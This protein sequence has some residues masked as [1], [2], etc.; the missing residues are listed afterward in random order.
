ML[1]Q[2]TGLMLLI[3]LWASIQVS[4]TANPHQADIEDN[5]FAEFEEFDGLHD[6]LICSDLHFFC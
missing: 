2:R 4:L 3:C 5:D 6:S 1:G